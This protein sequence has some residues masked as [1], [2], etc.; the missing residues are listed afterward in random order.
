MHKHVPPAAQCEVHKP[1]GWDDE[2]DRCYES[3][4]HRPVPQH[5]Q[6]QHDRSREGNERKRNRENDAHEWP[7]STRPMNKLKPHDVGT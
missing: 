2:R 4:R 3:A 5:R 7:L 1:Y 6:R